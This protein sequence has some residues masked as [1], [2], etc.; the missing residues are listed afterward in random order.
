MVQIFDSLS[1][2]YTIMLMKW[3]FFLIIFA[4]CAYMAYSARGAITRQMTSST[5]D[6]SQFEETVS[7]ESDNN[8][9][10]NILNVLRD[11]KN[12]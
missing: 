9:E 2:F 6:T 1:L 8:L 4:V 12:N 5:L 11:I 10:S 3:V 7:G